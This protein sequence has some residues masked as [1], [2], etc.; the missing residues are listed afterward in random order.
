MGSGERLGY[1]E[2]EPALARLTGQD[3]RKD[4]ESE[5]T[6]VLTLS[7]RGPA[8]DWMTDDVPETS[9]TNARNCTLA[10]VVGAVDWP[11]HQK[12]GEASWRL[13]V[14]AWHSIN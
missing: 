8:T 1:L 5:W 13:G 12:G 9:E 2:Q 4:F 6:V 14:L 10:P 11:E 7:G 3:K